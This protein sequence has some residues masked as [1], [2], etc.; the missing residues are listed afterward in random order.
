MSSITLTPLNGNVLPSNVSVT[1]IY[2]GV[3]QAI[4]TCVVSRAPFNT[5][6]L[7]ISGNNYVCDTGIYSINNLPSSVVIQSVT[8]S[9]NNIATVSL[10]GTN[11]ILVTKVSVDKITFSNFIVN[12]LSSRLY[13]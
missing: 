11:E 8:S 5:S 2:N 13:I 12:S 3:T 9:N 7:L 6:T 1:P 10:T 4:K